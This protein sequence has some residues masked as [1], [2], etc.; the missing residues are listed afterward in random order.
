MRKGVLGRLLTMNDTVPASVLAEATKKGTDLEFCR[1]LFEANFKG[2]E[3][4]LGRHE[5]ETFTYNN[6][7]TRIAWRWYL[8]AILDLAE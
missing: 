1:N 3:Y 6:T 2:C 7:N 5:T 4:L 8:R